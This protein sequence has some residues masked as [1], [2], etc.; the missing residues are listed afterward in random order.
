MLII[1]DK[2]ANEIVWIRQLIL[3]HVTEVK[4]V[5]SCI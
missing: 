4:L 2:N 3:S 5:F 1:K